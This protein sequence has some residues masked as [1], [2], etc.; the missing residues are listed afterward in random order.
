MVTSCKTV[1]QYSVPP[2]VLVGGTLWMALSS[3]IH[4]IFFI[5]LPRYHV[6]LVSFHL[7]L[8]LYFLWLN[9]LKYTDQLFFRI[10]II[11]VCLMSQMIYCRL[12]IFWHIHLSS[13]VVFSIHLTRKHMML[14]CPNISHVTFIMEKKWC[15]LGFS[16]IK[17]LFPLSN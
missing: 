15:P 2:R 3:N 9:F 13:D 1:T 10:S 6:S 11:W 12:C 7:F 5:T 8:R 14:V 4:C 17:L 16:I